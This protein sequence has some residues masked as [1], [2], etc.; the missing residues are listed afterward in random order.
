VPPLLSLPSWVGLY[1]YKMNK[2]DAN[3]NNSP[4]PWPSLWVEGAVAVAA[5]LGGALS[6]S[7]PSPRRGGLA[8]SPSLPSWRSLY[9]WKTN[10]LEQIK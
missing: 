7:P 10:E 3:Q 8:P 6:P 5:V 4:S 2:S 1:S 9:N